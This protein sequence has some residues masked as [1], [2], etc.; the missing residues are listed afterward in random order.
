MSLE[1]VK[2]ILMSREFS[3]PLRQALTQHAWNEEGTSGDDRHYPNM[4]TKVG[5]IGTGDNPTIRLYMVL[6][7]NDNSSEEQIEAM[8]ITIEHND[9]EDELAARVQAV[10]N[11]VV[12]EHVQ[13]TDD[14]TA[15]P[16]RDAT[17][18]SIVRNWKNFLY[19]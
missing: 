6:E 10:F 13:T 8:K 2:T 16:P 11:Q 19:S 7:V 14:R 15:E 3:V 4:I 1:D 12:G 9:D 18:E 17:N 5:V